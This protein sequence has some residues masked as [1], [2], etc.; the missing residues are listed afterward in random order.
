MVSVLRQ[1]A[2]PYQDYKAAD[3]WTADDL[4]KINE[5]KPATTVRLDRL[6][7]YIKGTRGR[8]SRRGYLKYLT[9]GAAYRVLGQVKGCKDKAAQ[10]ADL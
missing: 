10:R 4:R 5:A 6:M 7:N 3:F 8:S 1:P 9:Y 2:K